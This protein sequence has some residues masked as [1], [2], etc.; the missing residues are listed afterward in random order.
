M[1][2]GSPTQTAL[3]RLVDPTAGPPPTGRLDEVNIDAI[4]WTVLVDLAECHGVLPLV[5]RWKSWLEPVA[6]PDIVDQVTNRCRAI[7]AR[8]LSYTETLFEVLESLENEGIAALPFKGPVLDQA[9]YGSDSRR[10]YGDL[11]I[12]IPRDELPQATDAVLDLGFTIEDGQPPPARA[13]GSGVI[14]PP[15]L[16]EFTLHRGTIELELRWNIGDVDRPFRP[17]FETLWERRTTLTLQG[18]TVPALMPEDRLL[19]LA[20]HGTKHRWHLLKWITDFVAGTDSTNIDWTRLLEMAEDTGNRRRILLGFGLG[21]HLFDRSVPAP[22]DYALAGDHAVDEL[23]DAT[24]T[25]ITSDTVRRPSSTARLSF[26]LRATDSRT[27]R[28]MTLLMYRPLHPSPPEYQLVP[29]P[30]S[31]FGAYYLIR[32]L[33]LLSTNA[34]QLLPGRWSG[35][36][37]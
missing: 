27:D 10:E 35:R 9:V 33:R 8:N 17:R 4:D 2:E 21:E 28:L 1:S 32:P 23:I 34:S 12:L 3:R 29:L 11:D 25:A 22:I 37:G 18:R 30:S 31:L 20:F 16:D 6:P 5:H 36:S 24:T 13:I 15:M 26:N 14:R 7:A 19:M